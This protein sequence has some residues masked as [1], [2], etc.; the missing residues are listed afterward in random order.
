MIETTF[1]EE[2]ET[3]LFGEQAV[4]CGGFTELIQ[5]GFQTLVAA[6]YQPEIAYFECLHEVKLIVDQ[7]YENGISYMLYSVSDTAEY[8]AY[9]AG[10]KIVDAHVRA[11]MK[12]LLD[13]IQDGTFASQ[14]MAENESGRGNFLAQRAESAGQPNR[15]RGQGSAGDD[16]LAAQGQDTSRYLRLRADGYRG[17]NGHGQHRR[18]T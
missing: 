10:K 3:D 7:I 9:Y 11:A 17:V 16:A 13:R 2:C 1:T 18:A 12:E 15:N 14:W 5:A 4:L 8:G 6:G